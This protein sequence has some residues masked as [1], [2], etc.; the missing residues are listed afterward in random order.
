[1]PL[2]VDPKVVPV[3]YEGPKAE[4][5]EVKREVGAILEEYML[6]LEVGPSTLLPDE[7]GLYIRLIGKDVE[8]AT[9][10]WGS[11]LCGYGEGSMEASPGEGDK[12]VLFSLP[13]AEA[14]VFYNKELVPI[15]EVLADLPDGTGLQGHSVTVGARGGIELVPLTDEKRRSITFKNKEPMEV[16]LRYGWRFWEGMEEKYKN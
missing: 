15:F 6:A 8:E 12:S 14:A 4:G 9:V 11:I 7:R 10:E 5:G 16:G 1:M 3:I 2:K 13:S